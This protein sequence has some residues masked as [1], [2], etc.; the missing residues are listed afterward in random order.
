MET[1]TYFTPLLN[2]AL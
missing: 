1:K 2:E